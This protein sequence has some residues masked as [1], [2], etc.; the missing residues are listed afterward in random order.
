MVQ[1]AFFLASSTKY[2]AKQNHIN[3]AKKKV[4]Q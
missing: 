4:Y 3:Y 1:L 2:K